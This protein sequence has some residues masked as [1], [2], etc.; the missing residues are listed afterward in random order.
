MSFKS[1]DVCG[2]IGLFFLMFLVGFIAYVTQ[3]AWSVVG[4]LFIP[5]YVDQF[6][7][8]V[9]FTFDDDDDPE[10]ADIPEDKTPESVTADTQVTERNGGGNNVFPF[11]RTGT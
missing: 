6:P 9:Y 1:L 2:V 5:A 4:L 10:P 7:W 11:Q 8:S 3:S